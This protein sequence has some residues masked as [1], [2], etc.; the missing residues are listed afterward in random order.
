MRRSHRIASI[1]CALVLGAVA[2]P[3]QALRVD[4]VKITPTRRDDGHTGSSDAPADGVTT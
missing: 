3:G 1:G 4:R 2:R